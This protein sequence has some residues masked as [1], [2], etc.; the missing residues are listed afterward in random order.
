M[1]KYSLLVRRLRK[2]YTYSA[3]QL[4]DDF[5]IHTQT[6]RS[7]VK[8]KA[9]PL[10]TLGTRPLLVFSEDL[11]EWL[12]QKDKARKV[13]LELTQFHCMACKAAK[14][15]LENKAAFVPS[16]KLVRVKGICPTCYTF[17]NKVQAKHKLDIATPLLERVSLEDLH[18]LGRTKY[19]EKAHLGKIATST[20]SEPLLETHLY[21]PIMLI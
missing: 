2:N 15:P 11:R 20:P 5:A 1:S 16:G 19:S 18:I 4:Q 6:L 17:M 12:S 7:W 3:E 13:V 21:K 8:D 9:T 10:K 14:T